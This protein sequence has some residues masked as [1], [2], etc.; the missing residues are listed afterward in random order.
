[1][2]VGDAG[3]TELVGEFG[4]EDLFEQILEAAVIG[5]HDRVLGRQIDRPAKIEAVIHAGACKAADRLVQIIHR[6][7]DTAVRKVEYFAG[8]R[9][10]AVGRR[11]G[12]G[13]LAGALH[14]K[15][16]RAV[17]VAEGVTSDDDRTRP[18]RHEARH[19][20]AD[21]RLA[22]H[23]AAEDVA[24]GA[25]RRTVHFLE[26][27]FLDPF[28]I[29]RD[30][31]AFHADAVFLDGIRAVDS[32]LVVGLVSLLD[33]KVV[34]F[35]VYVQIGEDQLVFDFLPDDTGHLVA[36]DLDDRG[37][38]FDL[39][40]ESILQLSHYIRPV[41]PHCNVRSGASGKGSAEA[42]TGRVPSTPRLVTATL[43][44]RKANA[45]VPHAGRACK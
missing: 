38:H 5:F 21:D 18:A 3:G 42:G 19:V 23:S 11:E 28:F 4:L 39:G 40:H 15:I 44:M 8:D 33:A 2:L 20:G 9:G 30:C 32:D 1:M 43:A 12:H 25:V 16:G 34:I 10:A 29:R 13:Q 41:M 35:Q 6:H 31:R 36:V 37:L 45:R 26:T 17:L 27:E 14:Y 7:G 22:E 24:D